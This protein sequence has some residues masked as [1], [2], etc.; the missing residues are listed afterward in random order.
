[1]QPKSSSDT[2]V[3]FQPTTLH[4]TPEDRSV[5]TH[6]CEEL[7]SYIYDANSTLGSLP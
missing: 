6:F 1:M 3:D 4:Y 7:K 5:A 2:S